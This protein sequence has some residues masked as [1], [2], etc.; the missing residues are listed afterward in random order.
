M[1]GEAAAAADKY[2]AATG[3]ANAEVVRQQTIA[4]ATQ[5]AR[6]NY[7]RLGEMRASIGKSGGTAG[8]FLDVLADTAAQGELAKQNIIYEGAVKATN[9][10]RGALLDQTAATSARLG[11]YLQAGSELTRGASSYGTL[12][13][14]GSS[15]PGVNTDLHA[16]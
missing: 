3:F 9:I 1:Q 16:G 15:R 10:T 2:N 11:G 5:Q 13:R 8:S 14:A 7:L 12:M 6:E 4:Q